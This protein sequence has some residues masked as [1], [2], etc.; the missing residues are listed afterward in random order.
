M[1]KEK[2]CKP[3][4]LR[5]IKNAVLA[6]SKE[7]T[8]TALGVRA[9]LASGWQLQGASVRSLGKTRAEHMVRSTNLNTWRAMY[10]AVQV[11]LV[12]ASQTIQAM[13]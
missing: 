7:Q 11:V 2:R 4:K 13:Q 6:R 1:A 10:H 5:A 8:I 9:S 3:D 12:D